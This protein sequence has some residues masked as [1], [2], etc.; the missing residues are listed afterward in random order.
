MHVKA[1][2]TKKNEILAKIA[3]LG[4]FGQILPKAPTVKS[5]KKKLLQVEIENTNLGYESTA[6]PTNLYRQVNN[7]RY[8]KK[9]NNLTL[10][11]YHIHTLQEFCQNMF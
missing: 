2:G 6:L 1:I 4:I 10:L 5:M 11:G 7:E 3:F 8:F 9:S